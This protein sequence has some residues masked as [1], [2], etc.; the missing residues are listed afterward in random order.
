MTLNKVTLSEIQ[1]TNT[2]IK[3]KKCDSQLNG[4]KYYYNKRNDSKHNYT[5]C[6]IENETL[7]IDSHNAEY[8]N[9][10]DYS[11]CRCAQCRN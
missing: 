10:S 8:Q 2:K 4:T 6:I 9:K 1:H 3:S 5:Q 11:E 7:S